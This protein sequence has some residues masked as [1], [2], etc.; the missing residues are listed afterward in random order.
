MRLLGLLVILVV[1]AGCL[2]ARYANHVTLAMLVFALGA[3]VGFAE[4]LVRFRDEPFQAVNA[5]KPR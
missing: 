2:A 5:A 1:V 3:F 4:I